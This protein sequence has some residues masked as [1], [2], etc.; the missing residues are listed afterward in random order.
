MFSLIGFILFCSVGI[1]S[2]LVSIE[3]DSYRMMVLVHAIR[4]TGDGPGLTQRGI[5]HHQV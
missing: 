5:A 1:L 3:Q 4:K 2:L